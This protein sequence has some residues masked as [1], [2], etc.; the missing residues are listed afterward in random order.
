MTSVFNFVKKHEKNSTN[1]PT[2]VSS[3]LIWCLIHITLCHIC[4]ITKATSWKHAHM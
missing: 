2:R 3:S 4:S 1:K